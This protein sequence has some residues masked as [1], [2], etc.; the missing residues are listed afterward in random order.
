MQAIRLLMLCLLAGTGIAFAGD[1]Q[2][3]GLDPAREI[4]HY[5]HRSWTK[6]DG[7]PQNTV[8]SIAQTPDGYLWFGTVEG[9]VRFDGTSFR[10]Y[11][12]RNTPQLEMNYISALCAT[13]D[14]SLYIGNYAGTILRWH[15]G[16]LR[17]VAPPKQLEHTMIRRFYE[18]SHGDLWVATTD[19][20]LAVR[21][22]SVRRLFTVADGLPLSVLTAVCEGKD[23]RIYVA[24]PVGIWVRNG[25]CFEPWMK[26]LSAKAGSPYDFVFAQPQ[27]LNSIPIDMMCDAGGSLWIATR[28]SGLFRFTRGVLT[29]FADVK[30]LRDVP[31]QRVY[32][33]RRGTIWIGTATHGLWRYT[34]GQF[35]SYTTADGLSGDE[36]MSMLEDRE[37]NLWVGVS[38][39]GVNRFTNST[40]T[41]F[42]VGSS[43]VENMIWSVGEGPNGQI[44][45][46]SASGKIFTMQGSKFVADPAYSALHNGVVAVYFMDRSGAFWVGGS[47]GLA[48]YAGG[49]GMKILSTPVTTIAEDRY[50]RLW[51]AGAHGI[52]IYDGGKIVPIFRDM[53]KGQFDIRQISFD[54]KNTVYCATRTHGLC[55]FPLPAPGVR[56]PQIPAGKLQWSLLENGSAAPWIVTMS[57]DSL[58]TLWITTMGAGLKVVRGDSVRTLTA[59]DG[60][61]EEVMYTGLHDHT[62]HFWFSSNSGVYR[63]NTSDLYALLDH[64]KKRVE[65]E[66]FGISDGMYSDECNGGHQAS[67]LRSKDGR[68]WFPTT[69]GVV[70]VD[71]HRMPVNNV[72]PAVVIER[73]VVDNVEGLVAP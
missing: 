64:R 24:T 12:V 65:F 21:G 72:P 10:T 69:S 14:S 38:T 20:L 22:D 35:S 60:L 71:P 53:T 27:E 61:P 41:T 15:R 2:A 49:K 34:G 5:A 26:G 50:G 59:A 68:L 33:D 43:V 31:I 52:G 17:K 7:L 44:L 46:S 19:G 16:V 30:G 1:V 63:A 23:G 32:Q 39:G 13:R 9:V 66:S 51:V 58:E 29:S 73:M 67:A 70:M 57:I 4:S 25:D 45:A 56:P 8:E 48:R 36:I 18:D 42:R 55:W 11:N 28:S 40:F 37:G 54:R 3:G 47:D 62:G 6:R